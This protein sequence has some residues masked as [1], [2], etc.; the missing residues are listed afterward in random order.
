MT[1]RELHLPSEKAELLSC[2]FL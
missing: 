2:Y 1:T